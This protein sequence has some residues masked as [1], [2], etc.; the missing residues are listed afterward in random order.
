MK[1][2]FV[3]VL[4]VCLCFLVGCETETKIL[5]AHISDITGALSTN[6]AIK[7]TLDNEERLKEKYVDVQ[8]KSN[9]DNQVLKF[10]QELGDNHIIIIPKKDYWYNLTYL[11]SNSNGISKDEGYIKYEE[12]GDRVF[13]FS[14]QNDVK[15]SFRVVAGQTKQNEQTKEEILVLSEEISEEVDI[16][17]KKFEDK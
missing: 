8:I 10:G 9:L 16:D 15:L 3:L 14:S 2:I 5:S 7:V 11:I 13:R 12:Y 17:V 4:C 6:Y 1:K